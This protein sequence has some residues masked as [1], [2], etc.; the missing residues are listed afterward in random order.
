MIMVFYGLAEGYQNKNA[1]G[2]L[3]TCGDWFG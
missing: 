3:A 2:A 1:A